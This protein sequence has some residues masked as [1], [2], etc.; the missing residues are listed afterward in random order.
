MANTAT[1][2]KQPNG[3]GAGVKT[4]PQRRLTQAELDS[5]LEKAADLLRGGVDHSEFRGYVFALLF[6]KR[7]NDVYL[8]NI[9]SLEKELGDPELARDPRMHD[10]VVPEDS[11]W[12]KV[13]RTTER[14]LGKALNDAMLAIE[15]A[16][17][18]K[19]DGILANSA[20]DFNAQ[21]RLPRSKLVS[22]INHYGSLPL[23]RASVHDD[24]FGNAYE[25]L[26]RNFASKAGKSSGEFYTPREVAYLM[27]EI[28][29]PQPGH[30]VC[31][32]AAGSGGLLL[33][34]RNYVERHYS[35]KEAERLFFYMQE[36]NNS[37]ANIARIN[38]YLHGVRG[39]HQAPPTDSLRA[40]YFREGQTR[41]LRQFDR[42]VMNP[43]FSLEDWGYDDFSGGDPYDRFGSGMPP[44]ENGDYAW[45][46]HVVKSLKT[47]GRAIIVMSQGVLFR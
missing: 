7:I 4:R 26:I 11:L 17:T 46:L 21:D 42:I 12:D 41:R 43:P 9:A 45:L 37:T 8:E 30:H 25:Y 28:V 36:S 18:P 3:N 35:K 19:F 5:F 39:F 44:R 22:I 2:M 33:Q 16:N 20:V 14:D 15:R 47:T 10:F 27:S 38:M 29:E 13:A 1:E 34:C 40:P 24:L 32:W 31:D 23:N 6:Y